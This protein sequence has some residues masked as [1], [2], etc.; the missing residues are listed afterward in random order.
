MSENIYS[1]PTAPAE[2]LRKRSAKK[3]AVSIFV[4]G[5][6][7]FVLSL[8]PTWNFSAEI[9]IASEVN[10][11]WTE[12]GEVIDSNMGEGLDSLGFTFTTGI[13]AETEAGLCFGDFS[14]DEYWVIEYM[15]ASK[16][17]RASAWLPELNWLGHVWASYRFNKLSETLEEHLAGE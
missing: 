15:A 6:I 5:F 4:G 1:P 3:L 2:R 17:V 12:G 7:L 8:L 14:V 10:P 11:L 9:V 13:G 16:Q